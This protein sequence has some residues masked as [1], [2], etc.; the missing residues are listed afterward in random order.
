MFEFEGE[1]F[2]EQEVLDA[3]TSLNLSFDD[4]VKKYN[5]KTVGERSAF[6]SFTNWG[7]ETAAAKDAQIAAAQD[8]VSSSEPASLATP[9][10]VSAEDRLKEV[11]AEADKIVTVAKSATAAGTED[12]YEG[13]D[14]ESAEEFEEAKAKA[15]KDYF[16][17]TYVDE[18][19]ITDET[20]KELFFFFK[21]DSK[22]VIIC[23]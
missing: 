11:A 8:M 12:I 4:Y 3:A 16:R 9:A 13:A 10:E 21:L 19:A 15:K 17:A 14:F 2:T 5:V 1:Q 20:K 22:E 23:G 7:K 18:Q 6:D